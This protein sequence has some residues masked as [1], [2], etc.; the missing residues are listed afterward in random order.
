ML[1][2]NSEGEESVATDVVYVDRKVEENQFLA[3]GKD[4]LI[5]DALQIQGVDISPSLDGKK[6]LVKALLHR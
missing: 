6:M 5:A 4:A 2:R 1:F 3:Q